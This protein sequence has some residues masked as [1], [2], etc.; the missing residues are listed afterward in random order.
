MRSVDGLRDGIRAAVIVHCPTSLDSTCSLAMLQEEVAEA[1]RSKDFK[2]P[3][4][5]FSTK[6]VPWG[7]F[8]LP[9]PPKI[10]KI[11]VP[12]CDKPA[13]DSEKSLVDRFSVLR[14]YRRA[15]GLCDKCAEKWRPGHQ[16]STTI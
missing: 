13:A 15:R 1:P 3:D 12:T 6:T 2:W 5:G 11:L 16:W 4:S 10:D 7:S 8:P 9:P 14:W